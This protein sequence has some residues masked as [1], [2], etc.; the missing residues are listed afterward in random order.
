MLATPAYATA[1]QIDVR[2]SKLP[3]STDAVPRLAA[4]HLDVDGMVWLVV[5]DARTQLDRLRGLGL[6]EPVVVD[7][8]GRSVSNEGA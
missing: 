5:G 6:G 4:E 1:F 3:D 8:E 7:R 2:P